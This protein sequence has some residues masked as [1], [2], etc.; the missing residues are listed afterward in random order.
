MIQAESL[1]KDF[2]GPDGAVR[3]LDG[4][5]FRVRSGE[6]F[7]V[8]G[9]SGCGKTTLLLTVG[10]M[11][12]PSAGR[13]LVDGTDPYSLSPAGR[14]A[15][16]AGNIGFVFQEFH[17]IPYLTVLENVLAASLASPR[18]DAGERARE[19]VA[20]FNLQKRIDHTPAQL[21]T[22]ECQRTAMARAM[23]NEPKLLLADEPTGN[24]D[25]DNAETVLRGLRE[26][27]EEGGGVLLV[28]HD[29]EA[30]AHADRVL[31]MRDGKLEE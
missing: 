7:A 22:G 27:A 21:S 11:L 12:R 29:R 20:R 17:L 15:F 25:S 24:L 28:T 18:S 6:F 3:A 13:V 30:A 31:H 19:L 9:P 1:T 14:N 23:L 8:Q 26:F 16:R 4:V 10:A 5:S 2:T